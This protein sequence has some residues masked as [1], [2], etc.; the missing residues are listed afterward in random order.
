[1]LSK[2]LIPNL[3]RFEY[4]LCPLLNLGKV[5][6]N[7]NNIPW[8]WQDQQFITISSSLVSRIA[9]LSQRFGLFQ[10]QF[11]TRQIL[12]QSHRRC[13]QSTKCRQR[14]HSERCQTKAQELCTTKFIFPWTWWKVYVQQ[15]FQVQSQQF[16]QLL[17]DWWEHFEAWGLGETLFYCAYIALPTV[18]A[19]EH[20][21]I[22]MKLLS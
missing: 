21:K 3:L 2:R 4:F 6:Y 9:S 12:R 1:M 19:S 8:N 10:T 11:E 18:F 14:N 20:P 15:S 7:K 17:A 16:W 13:I 5:G 22:P